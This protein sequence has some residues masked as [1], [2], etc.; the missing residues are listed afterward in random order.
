ML[1]RMRNAIPTDAT[2][3]AKGNAHAAAFDDNDWSDWIDDLYRD[4]GGE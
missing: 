1:K 3:G 2:R 4:E